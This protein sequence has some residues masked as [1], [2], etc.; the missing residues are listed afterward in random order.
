MCKKSQLRKKKL[1]YLS[2]LTFMMPINSWGIYAQNFTVSG[3]VKDAKNGEVLP[4]A[5]VIV[6][7]LPQKGTTTN[8][9]GYYAIS[10][11]RGQHELQYDFLGYQSIIK[12]LNIQKDTLINNC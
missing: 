9:Y 1:F 8:Y 7:N 6:N 12:D 10:L 5:S 11:P 2:I 4:G 3:T